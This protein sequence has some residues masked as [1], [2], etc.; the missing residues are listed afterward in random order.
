M[1]SKKQSVQTVGAVEKLQQ[2]IREV[3]D[4]RTSREIEE[5]VKE[6]ERK[7]KKKTVL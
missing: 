2:R 3:D 5:M 1:E 7:K 4:D 6:S